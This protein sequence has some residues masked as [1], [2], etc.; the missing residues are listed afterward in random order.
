MFSNNRL[1]F[2]PF[3]VFQKLSAHVRGGSRTVATSKMELFVIIVNGFQPLT[4]STKSSKLDVAAVLDLPLH[5]LWNIPHF[6]SWI[7]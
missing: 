1:N 3:G 6:D 4:I 5:V 2:E 7:F